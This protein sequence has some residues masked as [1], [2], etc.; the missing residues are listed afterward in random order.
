MNKINDKSD[1]TYANIKNRL[2][3]WAAANGE[4]I[5]LNIWTGDIE[6]ANARNLLAIVGKDN[7]VIVIAL[8]SAMSLS[9]LVIG[10]IYI[11]RRRKQN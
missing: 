8:I 10:G 5:S 6:V 9:L 11:A 4:T 1:A 7:S 3:A 2:V